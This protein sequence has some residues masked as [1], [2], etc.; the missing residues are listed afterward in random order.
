ML[1]LLLLPGIHVSQNL[2]R[3]QSNAFGGLIGSNALAVANKLSRGPVRIG[4][5]NRSRSDAGQIAA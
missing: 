5:A 1:L 4:G 3:L 2:D